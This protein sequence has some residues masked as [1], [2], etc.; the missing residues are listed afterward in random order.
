MPEEQ[1]ND[2]LLKAAMDLVN[3]QGEQEEIEADTDEQEDSEEQPQTSEDDEEI[4]SDDHQD[5]DEESDEDDSADRDDDTFD[6]TIGDT[7]Q[8]VSLKELKSG[9]MRQADYTKKTQDLSERRSRYET[10]Q[11]SF[12]EANKRL[13]SLLQEARDKVLPSLE[14]RESAKLRETLNSIDVNTLTNEQLL[15]YN[16]LEIAAQRMERDEA[17]KEKAYKDLIAKAEAERKK[18]EDEIIARGQAELN[19]LIPGYSTPEKREA[20]QTDMSNVLISI[21]GEK[22]AREMAPTIRSKEDMLTL[23]YASL[24]KKF[25]ETKVPDK[26]KVKS[27]VLKANHNAGKQEVVSKKGENA[28]KYEAIMKGART[29]GG[30]TD[31]EAVNLLLMKGI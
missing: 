1:G 5:E 30:L 3:D 2:E 13:E 28:K 23:Y 24:G 26:G 19:D 6:V 20:I 17:A 22:R 25:L 14:F 11:H 15:E 16:K 21:Y 4:A 12:E 27:P 18:A 31:E 8:K 9:Y 29:R 10:A 7:T